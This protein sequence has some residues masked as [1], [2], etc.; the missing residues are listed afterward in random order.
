MGTISHNAIIVTDSDVEW[1]GFAIA[2]ARELGCSVLGPSERVTNAYR[3]I[4]VCPDGSKEGWNA[5]DAGNTARNVFV[6]WLVDERKSGNYSDWA[7]VC[8]GELGYG[9]VRSDEDPCPG[10]YDNRD[11]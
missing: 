11:E 9:V 1:L 2:K 4:V 5:S 7:E 10:P 6:Q 3:T 8:Y